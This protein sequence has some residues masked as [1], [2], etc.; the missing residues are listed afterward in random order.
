MYLAEREFEA[1][2]ERIAGKR[3][4]FKKVSCINATL[5]LSQLSNSADELCAA[6]KVCLPS[7]FNYN[8]P[9]FKFMLA[10]QSIYYDLF[11]RRCKV[12]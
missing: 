2:K 4:G 9:T 5:P 3:E 12:S 8:A 1:L 7:F 6:C 11:I 10:Y